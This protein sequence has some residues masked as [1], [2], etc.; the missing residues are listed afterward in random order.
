MQTRLN[1][2]DLAATIASLQ[3]LVEA[4]A[5][6]LVL[7]LSYRFPKAYSYHSQ[8]PSYA[9]DTSRSSHDPTSEVTPAVPTLTCAS[10]VGLTTV[11]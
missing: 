5:T 9:A 8:S 2:D 11:S 7:M 3:P 4:G 1:Y 10:F 6:H